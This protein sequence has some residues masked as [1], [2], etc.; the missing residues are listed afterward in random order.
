VSEEDWVGGTNNWHT[1]IVSSSGVSWRNEATF[2]PL[3]NET[4]EPQNLAAG[5]FNTEKSAAEV[6]VRSRLGDETD[7]QHPWVF[8]NDGDLY[9]HYESDTSLPSG[10][11]TNPLGGNKQGIE[12][13]W[14]IDWDG[15]DQEYIAATARHIEGNVGVFHADDLQPVWYTPND[16]S[17]VQAG[18]LYVA[19]VSGDSREEVII[20]DVADGKIK[21]YWNADA[22]PDPGPD[23]WD[24]PLY[25]RVKQNWNYYSPGSY[26]RRDPLTLG[27]KIFLEG[28]YDNQIHAMR[29][30]LYPDL[31]PLTS[32]YPQDIR[33]L[34]SLPSDAVDWVLIEL[35]TEADGPP[36][37]SRSALLRD[38]GQIMTGSG[39]TDLDLFAE[40]DDYYV[41]IRHRN[42]LAVMS[43]TRVDLNGG[44][45]DYDFTPYENRF[46]GDDAAL[47][48]TNVYGMYSGDANHNGQVQNDDI[49]DYWKDQVGMAGYKSADFNLNGQVQNDD[50]NDHWKSNVGKGA[51]I[52]GARGPMD[53]PQI[54][55]RTGHFSSGIEKG[56]NPGTVGYH[57][58]DCNLSGIVTHADR[59]A[60]LINLNRGTNVED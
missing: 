3:D 54:I 30:D 9:T 12:V 37:I 4:R 26:T 7:S 52:S 24:D 60:V 43:K 2:W 1:A 14:T 44:S 59:E 16:F 10:F 15:G 17:G 36:V 29:T 25:K 55:I 5:N 13:I 38:D 20:Y 56:T 57:A 32:P 42:H 41:V 45:N 58:A 21:I 49:N 53:I 33:S 51:Q 11:N 18:M 28:A 46:Y 22:N 39:S 8:D 34:Q 50:R 35:R 40:A 27:V 6:W 47:C 19:D 23:K 31:I 48:E